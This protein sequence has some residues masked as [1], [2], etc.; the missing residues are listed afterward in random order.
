[1]DTYFVFF[2]FFTH[3]E[4]KKIEPETGKKKEG[5]K[6]EGRTLPP[7]CMMRTVG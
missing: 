5:T 1:M 6:R 3:G 7:A 2:V 4:N